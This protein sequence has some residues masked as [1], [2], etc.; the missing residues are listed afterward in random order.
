[1]KFR[2]GADHPALPGHFPGRPIVPGVVILDQVQQAIA[3][4]DAAINAPLKLAQV[5]F[6]YPLLPGEDAEIALEATS[7][8]WKFRVLRNDALIASGDIAPASA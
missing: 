5:K 2:I 8:G 1:M 3:C 7:H 6:L 4:S